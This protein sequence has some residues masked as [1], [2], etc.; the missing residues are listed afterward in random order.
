MSS[1]YVA[2]DQRLLLLQAKKA[3]LEKNLTRAGTK[4]TTSQTQE[5]IQNKALTRMEDELDALIENEADP[6]EI[7]SRGALCDQMSTNCEVATARST[8]LLEDVA[9]ID[10]QIQEADAAITIHQHQEVT[11]VPAAQPLRVENKKN[12]VPADAAAPAVVQVE[13]KKYEAP[14]D[15]A[16]S[17]APADEAKDDPAKPADELNPEKDVEPTEQISAA[18][19]DNDDNMA[20]VDGMSSHSSE[21]DYASVQDVSTLD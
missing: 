8:Q 12:G 6:T 9:R 11:V 16:V 21:G 5:D 2:P 14:A 19:G 18:P 3:R 20:A 7:A 17:S 13:N 1:A 4:L 10:R 15:A